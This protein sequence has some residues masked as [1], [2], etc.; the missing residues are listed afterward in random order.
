MRFVT[1]RHPDDPTDRVGLVVGGTVLGLPPGDDLIDLLRGDGLAW[2]GHEAGSQPEEEVPLDDVVLRPPVPQPTSFRDFMGF[3]GHIRA[4]RK[5]RGEE[6]PDAWYEEPAFYFSSPH[7]FF[8]P[9]EEVP[10]PPGSDSLDFE[11]EVAAVVGCAGIDLDPEDALHHIAGFTILNDW[12]ARDVQGR[13]MQLGLGP[14]KGKDFA[15]STGPVLVTPDE[16]ENHREGGRY[17]LQMSVRLRRAGEDDATLIATGSLADL[18]WSF[19]ELLAY[20]SRGSCIA[21]GDVV[22]TGTVG[23]GCLLE[24]ILEGSGQEWLAPGDEVIL[25]VDELGELRNTVAG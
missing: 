10:V 4:I 5:A 1:Y 17:D 8:G 16:L 20:A 21:P 24:P 6:V 11:L 13:E 15:T 22:G 14:A 7:R 18:H 12:S 19:G 9:D 2:A 23:G 3:E 25:A